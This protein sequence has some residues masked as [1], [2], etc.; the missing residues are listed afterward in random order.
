VLLATTTLIVAGPSG[1][2]RR[3]TKRLIGRFN[4]WKTYTRVLVYKSSSSSENTHSQLPM[5]SKIFTPAEDSSYLFPEYF[6]SGQGES[7]GTCV[8]YSLYEVIDIC[9]IK[10]EFWWQKTTS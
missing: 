9:R 3:T 7:C 2:F 6:S 8:A 5:R 10:F 4:V 1:W